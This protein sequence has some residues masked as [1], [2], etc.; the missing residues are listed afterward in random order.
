MEMKFVSNIIETFIQTFEANYSVCNA[1]DSS[2]ANDFTK[3]E[4]LL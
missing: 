2:L 3:M 1:V 4:N